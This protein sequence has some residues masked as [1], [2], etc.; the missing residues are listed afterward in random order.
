MENDKSNQLQPTPDSSDVV[1]PPE[2][3]ATAYTEPKPSMPAVELPAESP[4][5]PKGNKIKSALST[6]LILLA[7][8]LIALS[9]INFIFQPYQVDGPSMQTTLFHNDRLII[10]KVSRTWA[11]ITKHD[12]IPHR[13]D[14]IVFKLRGSLEPGTN[15]EKQLI[16]RVIALPGER[17]VVKDNEVT[18][19]NSENP[20]GFNPDEIYEYG[21]VIKDTARDTDVTVAAGQVFVLGDNRGNS[22]DSR[23]FGTIPAEDI[24]G[25]LV[26]R[27]LPLKEAERF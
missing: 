5:P 9:I 21:K 27:I 10:W 17:V 15:K 13:G 4:A 20:E 8:P 12:Y 26:A 22:E 23:M 2:V 18:V 16:K 24:V 19:F 7:A 3:P 1:P 14:V 6:I 11:R 25:K